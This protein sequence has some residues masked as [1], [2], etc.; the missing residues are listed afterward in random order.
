MQPTL[1]DRP[2][3]L[4]LFAAGSR[5]AHHRSQAVSHYKYPGAEHFAEALPV[6][7]QVLTKTSVPADKAT[8]AI[9]V[10]VG[11]GATFYPGQPSES[12]SAAE[13]GE[14]EALADLESLENMKGEGEAARAIPWNLILPILLQLL[15]EWLSKKQA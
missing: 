14:A 9:Y 8:H 10:A 6:L 11:Y 12:L 7:R 5:A 1:R 2:T 3:L 13:Y 4:F 15:Q